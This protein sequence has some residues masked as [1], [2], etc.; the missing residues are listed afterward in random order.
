MTQVVKKHKKVYH[1]SLQPLPLLELLSA[2]DYTT[3]YHR[4]SDN[5]VADAL[6]RLAA[7]A[8]EYGIRKANI[9]GDFLTEVT[10]K[11]ELLQEVAG[12]M[13]THWPN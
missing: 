4:G 9:T 5:K 8:E 13:D 6:S 10:A 1:T 3:V 12:Y 11:D 7:K 2:L